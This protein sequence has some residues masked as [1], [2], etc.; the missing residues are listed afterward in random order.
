MR[1]CKPEGAIIFDIRNSLNPL[2]FIKYKL[3]KYYDETV[4][5][6][7]LPLQTYRLKKVRDLL[8]KDGF[9]ITEL[10]PISANRGRYL[11]GVF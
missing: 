1:I 10:L 6:R 8:K 2:L 4:R 3:A 11:L 5:T 9:E 7:N